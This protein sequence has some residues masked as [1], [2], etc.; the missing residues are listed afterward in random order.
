MAV[1]STQPLTEMSTRN[2]PGDKGRPA[3]K[4][5]NL[6]AICEP[7]AWKIWQPRCVTNLW[8][9]K[10]CYWNTFLRYK[11]IW[12]RGIVGTL[13]LT[14]PLDGVEWSI[15]CPRCFTPGELDR[16]LGGPR[17]SLNAV[18]YVKEKAI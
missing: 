5:N 10:A 14:L 2:L 4:A 8:A 7:N 6:T 13:F 18:E 9:S 1:G 11:D 16:R 15:S 12:G 17:A 3:H